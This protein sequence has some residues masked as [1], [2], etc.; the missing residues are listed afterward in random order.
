[1]VVVIPA[2][3]RDDAADTLRS[4]LCYTEAER[5]LVIDD[6][7]G[8]G[9]GIADRRIEVLT[10]PGS[11]PGPLGGLWV[12]EAAALRYAA[13]NIEFDIAL[14]LDTDALILGPGIAEA[15]AAR[16][17][18]DPALGALGAYR[19]GPDGAA[20]DWGPAAR[21]LRAHLGPRGLRYPAVRRR[22]RK[23]L[24][25][26]PGYVPGEHALGCAVLF[27]GDMIRAMHREGMLDY[28][29]LG[30]ARLGE[31]HLFGLLTAAAGYRTGDFGGP[32]DPLAV[33]WVGLPASPASLLASGKL[34][35]HSV[36]SWEDMRE[37][38]IRGYFAA[39]RPA[40]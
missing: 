22:L 33:R 18:A 17:A 26:S 7:G 1:M 10:P 14:R 8:R 39:R 3:P 23:L 28:P 40:A 32:L 20:R 38:E 12:K 37:A 36:R 29:E 15:A 21:M 34:I 25:S 24:A 27:R 6:T 5:I 4:V 19:I 11:P 31:D 2:G 9:I 30:H 16:F 13:R 35:T